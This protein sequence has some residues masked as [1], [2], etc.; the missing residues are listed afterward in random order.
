[1]SHYFIK[2]LPLDSARQDE[3]IDMSK[4]SRGNLLKNTV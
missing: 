2:D 1:M 4:L 3:S